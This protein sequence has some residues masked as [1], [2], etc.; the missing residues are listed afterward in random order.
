MRRNREEGLQGHGD[1]QEAKSV[2]CFHQGAF[3][4][5]ALMVKADCDDA[6]K[7]GEPA[8]AAKGLLFQR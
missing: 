8:A 1:G 4:N 2:R 7:R 6:I 5:K 3:C